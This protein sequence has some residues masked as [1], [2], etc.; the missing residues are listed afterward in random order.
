MKAI[1]TKNVEDKI[2][3]Y[4]CIPVIYGKIDLSNIPDNSLEDI[5]ATDFLDYID[6]DKVDEYLSNI[7][8]KMR[9]NSTLTLR[10]HELGLLCR[11]TVNNTITSKDFNQLTSKTKSIHKLPDV[12][13]LLKSK[14]LLI[15]NVTIKGIQYEISSIRQMQN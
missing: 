11:N 15:N 8:K 14:N 2:I 10:G 3:G 7:C 6:V 5:I 1:I 9:M 12:I 4:E 13:N